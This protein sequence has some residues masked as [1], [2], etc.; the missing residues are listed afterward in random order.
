MQGTPLG[1]C[2]YS[3]VRSYLSN[4]ITMLETYPQHLHLADLAKPFEKPT[5]ATPLRF[6][7]TTY[8]GE[9]HPAAKKVVCEFDP[10]DLSLT[11]TQTTK[12]I[13]LLG[14]RYNPSTT[15]AKISSESF[16]TQAQNKRYIGDMIATLMKEAKDE[17][18]TFADLPFDFRHHKPK[19][20]LVF[21]E[22][23]L[24]TE[25]R[26]RELEATRTMRLAAEEHRKS[27]LDG[28]VDGVEAIE[29]ARRVKLEQVEAP[30]MA[31]AK[32]PLPK[33][34]MGKKQMGQKSR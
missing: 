23:W 3:L 11:T 8:L 22:R 27:L 26:K 7:Y 21:P 28:L 20:K 16:E 29:N 25:D 1:R 31:E 12:L 2:L 10:T 17:T 9:Q 24:L 5:S 18:D 19:P 33:G 14:Q 6:R 32:A 15:L 4:P 13:K 30:I 34:K